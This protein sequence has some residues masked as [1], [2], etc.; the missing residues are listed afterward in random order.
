MCFNISIQLDFLSINQGKTQ[1]HEIGGSGGIA[2]LYLQ[3]IQT[4]SNW[5]LPEENPQQ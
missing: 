4:Q 5:R 2:V 1:L 3:D